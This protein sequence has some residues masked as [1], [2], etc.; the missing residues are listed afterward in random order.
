MVAPALCE[1]NRAGANYSSGVALARSADSRVL[2]DVVLAVAVD[3]QSLPLPSS[4]AV[5]PFG[6]APARSFLHAAS[7]KSRRPSSSGLTSPHVRWCG[8]GAPVPV[9]ALVDRGLVVQPKQSSAAA[10]ALDGGSPS[11]RT[12]S[13]LAVELERR[14]GCG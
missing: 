12:V 7:E 13:C 8:T 1:S 5:C 3:A 6:S 14:L 11:N 4:G 2:W 9:L 10:Y